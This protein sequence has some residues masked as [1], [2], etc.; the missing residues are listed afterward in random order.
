M[1]RFHI[2]VSNYKRLFS[3]VENFHKIK[4]FQADRDRL[5]ILDCSPEEDWA[6]ELEAARQLSAY[7]L[8]WG[9]SVFFIR[10]RNWAQNFGA[11]LDYYRWSLAGNIPAAAYHFFMQEH[12]LD[13]ERFLNA[14][15]IPDGF[16]LDL[17]AIEQVFVADR[18]VGC[19]FATRQG[20]R[21]SV[22]QPYLIQDPPLG[23][24][25][26]EHAPFKDHDGYYLHHLVEGGVRRYFFTDGGNGVVRAEPYVDYF[27][28]HPDLLVEGDGSFGFC[29]VWEER[30]GKILGDLGM[31]WV[32]LYNRAIF[33]NL[34]ELDAVEAR[35]GRRISGLWYENMNW[36]YYYGY[37][38]FPEDS[39]RLLKPS[40][41]PLM[42]P[43]VFQA[44]Q[45][46]V[47]GEARV[48]RLIQNADRG[49]STLE[50]NLEILK[51]QQP[52]LAERLAAIRDDGSVRV[53]P[54]RNGTCVPLIQNHP[55]HSLE[56]PQTEAEQISSMLLEQLEDKR[57]LQAKMPPHRLIL[58]GFGFGYYLMSLV[59][60]GVS[61]I[62]VEPNGQLLRKAFENVDLTEI[63]S[64]VHIHLAEEPAALPDIPRMT[65]VFYHP[66]V[67]KLYPQLASSLAAKIITDYPARTNDMHE[68]VYYG[69][70]RNVTCLK[71]P[72]DLFLYQMLFHIVRPTLVI[73]IGACRGGSAL[74]FADLLRRL[75]GDRRV[76]SY[77]ITHE[78]APEVVEDPQII[79]N[80]NGWQAFDP[81]II[82]PHDRVMVIEDSSHTYENTLQVMRRF[83]P[84]VSPN[85]YLI[86]EDGE[87]GY[88]R[89]EFNGGAIRAIE[90]FLT[91]TN[92][93]ELD[94]R[95]ETLYGNGVSECLKGYL[96]RKVS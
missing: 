48:E 88:T 19:A 14:D 75:G 41:Q 77:D 33:R 70:Y 22:S 78:I 66:V 23:L 79:F 25:G 45:L 47:P 9:K 51:K 96:R 85:S 17:N 40:F 91:E 37:D 63:L 6:A 39:K 15:S 65:Q 73:E 5:Y 81:A 32:D 69:A 86:V 95:W 80:S 64:F 20:I 67:Q 13:T 74:Y 21:V 52:N 1:D 92:E 93:F 83:A 7:A 31:K 60:R 72:V 76:Y 71:N 35:L 57:W 26:R 18:E 53:V 42:Q 84:F 3:F 36:I 55:L 62:V 61:P 68:G 30:L 89:P 87:S 43:G 38:L 82:R 49:K 8:E 28:A 56:E 27:R 24:E 34:D 10:R 11:L 90:E 29:V 44:A 54:T 58:F 4:N 50:R 2:V 16:D 59:K 46:P 94:R 12:Y